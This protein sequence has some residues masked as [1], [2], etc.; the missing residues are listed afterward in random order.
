MVYEI[1]AEP[2]ILPS[3]VRYEGEQIAKDWSFDTLYDSEV[4]RIHVTP[5]LKDGAID[6]YEVRM[7]TYST[8]YGE[9]FEVT[10]DGMI[11]TEDRRK[12][13]R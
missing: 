11:H 5:K 6:R 1:T 8:Y 2:S 13:V 10:P 3:M 9:S 7:D 4:Q 12:D